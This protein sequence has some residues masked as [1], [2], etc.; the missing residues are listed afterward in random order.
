[1]LADFDT[2]F[3]LS[4]LCLCI[5]QA[6]LRDVVEYARIR[7]LACPDCVVIPMAQ[8][9]P[10]RDLRECRPSWVWN[11]DDMCWRSGR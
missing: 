2:M 8:D 11:P 4:R 6:T 9:L 3:R 7:G 5:S 1:M 10:D